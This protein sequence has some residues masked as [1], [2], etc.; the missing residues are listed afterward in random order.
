MIINTFTD[1]VHYYLEGC[2]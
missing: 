2:N 1:L